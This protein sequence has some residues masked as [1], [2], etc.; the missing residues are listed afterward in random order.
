M[1]PS[2]II[3]DLIARAE[4]TSSIDDDAL[5][6]LGYG[7]LAAVADDA[8]TPQHLRDLLSRWLRDSEGRPS[9]SARNS[10]DEV[11]D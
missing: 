2:S 8:D 3:A 7:M 6:E 4:L 11:P 10:H 9:P 5:G 1:P